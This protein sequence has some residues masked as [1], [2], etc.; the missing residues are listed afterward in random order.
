MTSLLADLDRLLVPHEPQDLLA[1]ARTL[2]LPDDGGQHARELYDPDSHPAQRAFLEAY[3]DGGFDEFVVLGPTQDG[4]TWATQI[5]PTLWCLLEQRS[6][7]IYALPDRLL[8]DRLWQSKVRP[9]FETC[10]RPVLPTHGPGSEGGTPQSLRTQAGSLLYLLGAGA[11][12]EAGQAGVTGRCAFLDESDSIRPRFIKLL[13]ERTSHWGAQARRVRSS[14]IKGDDAKGSQLWADYQT[15]TQGRLWVPCPHCGHYQTLEWERVTYDADT[16]VS[17][18][19]SARFACEGC[20]VLLTDAERRVALH[21]AHLVMVGQAIVDG[22]VVGPVPP[23]SR[24]GIRWSALDSPFVDLGQL[25]LAHRQATAARDLHGDH[26]PLRQFYRDRLALPYTGDAVD[27]SG[28]ASLSPRS[29][30]LRSQAS[31]WGPSQPISDRGGD[32]RET[33]SHH[34]AP[35]PPDATGAVVA[36]DLQRDRVYWVLTAIDAAAREFDV[37]WGYDYADPTHAPL[38]ALGLA[39][40]LTR[41]EA[42]ATAYAGTCPI[43]A[44]GIDAGDGVML[45]PLLTFLITAPRWWALDGKGDQIAASRHPLDVPGTV[46]LT[47][48]G[49]WLLGPSRPL[50]KIASQT[51]KE[52][53]QTAY[54]RP[55]G[56][57]GAAHLPNGLKAN[58]A[59]L[60]HL[61]GE[62]LDS[63]ARGARKWVKTTGRHD[64]LDART[65]ARALLALFNPSRH[66]R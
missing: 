13:Y 5:V 16:D 42:A 46:Y 12:N 17:A 52:A 48:P 37:A 28:L 27:L 25:C 51:V 24:W 65:Y 56:T 63:T 40:T 26:D 59:Y 66:L 11:R 29:L 31:P 49:R 21:R 7:V 8:L 54:L 50:L 58:A 3:R 32:E 4:K 23:V 38:D 14:T 55:A 44:Y 6:S 22:Q 1:F 45:D 10:G 2:R 39:V 62:R 15:S 57:P 43:A 30:W 47:T 9:A 35:M 18:K 20:A 60:Q 61:C 64:W 19:A 41:V 33:F 34:V 53:T 36:C